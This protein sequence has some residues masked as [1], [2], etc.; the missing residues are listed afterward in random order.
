MRNELLQERAS[1]QDLECDKIALERQV[2]TP[3][4]RITATDSVQNTHS[5][6]LSFHHIHL[7]VSISIILLSVH[8]HDY[9]INIHVSNTLMVFSQRPL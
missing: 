1:R 4:W 2:H 8:R 9:G 3:V 5:F 7:I 6:H